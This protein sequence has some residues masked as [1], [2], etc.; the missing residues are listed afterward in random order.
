MG[1][2]TINPADADRA[3]TAAAQLSRARV[4][5]RAT[6]R[7]LT[8][9]SESVYWT[10]PI[11]DRV[12]AA[13]GLQTIV[14]LTLSNDVL[15]LAD[16][17]KAHATWI[18]REAARLDRLRGDVLRFVREHPDHPF[19]VRFPFSTPPPRWHTRW[20]ELAQQTGAGT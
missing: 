14:L 8:S 3:R 19:S 20:A 15:K 1:Y 5:L 13:L 12:V 6:A 9:E 18:D 2:A 10:G 7:A 11:R 4:H 16:E 17:L